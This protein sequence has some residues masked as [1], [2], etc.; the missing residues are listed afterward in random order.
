MSYLQTLLENLK[1]EI[2]YQWRIQSKNK[3]KS[4]A[5]C[6]AYVDARAVMEVLD[7]YCTYG[8]HTEVKEVAGFIFYG[9]GINIPLSGDENEDEELVIQTMWRWD[10]GS[11]I[12]NN[13]TDNMY[14]QAGK[15]AASDSFKR[16]AIHWGVARFV[17]NIPPVTLPC[18]GY[19]VVDDKGNRVWDLTKHI[20]NM[21]AKPAAYKATAEAPKENKLSAEAYDSMVKYITEGKIKEVEQAMKKYDLTSQQKTV[22]TALINKEK[23]KAVTA[24]V[25]K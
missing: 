15:S 22:L 5:I 16:A 14:E 6:S 9:I 7:S 19:N 21:K 11:R 1:K 17:Y 18:D 3:D 2:P 13:P 23:S 20:N 25:K 12:E 10:T 4:K 24:A 8:W